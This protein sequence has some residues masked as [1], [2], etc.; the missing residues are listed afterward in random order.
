MNFRQTTLDA[1]LQE[2]MEFK[3]F[4]CTR[5]MSKAVLLKGSDFRQIC[6]W[7]ECKYR[8]SIVGAVLFTTAVYPKMMS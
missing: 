4:K 7:K 1:V 5:C 3:D 8:E 6:T 2:V